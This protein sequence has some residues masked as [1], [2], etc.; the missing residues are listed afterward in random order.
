MGDYIVALS[1]W[2]PGRTRQRLLLLSAIV[3]AVAVGTGPGVAANAA[4]HGLTSIGAS[5]AATGPAGGR[6]SVA[7]AVAGPVVSSVSPTAGPLAGATTVTVLGSGFTSVKAVKFGGATATHLKVVSAAKLTVSAPSHAS[8]TVDV[9]VTTAKGTSAVSAHDQYAYVATPSVSSVSPPTGT[10]AGGTTVTVGGTGFTAVKTVTFGGIAGAGLT[11]ISA[12]ELTVTSPAHIAATVAVRVLTAGGTSPASSADQYA[13]ATPLGPVTKL[14]ASHTT[15]TVTLTWL[16]PA[17][18]SLAGVM[19]RRAQGT[20]A[21]SSPTSGTLV[22]DVT[23]AATTYT[24]TGLTPGATYSYAL[25]AYGNAGN[26]ASAATVTVTIGTLAPVD[27]S[28]TLTQDT[29]WSP[30]AASAYIIQGSLDVP[31]GVTLTIDPG[32]VVKALGSQL[33]VE[34]TLDA[35]GTAGSPVTFTSLNDNSA[36][37]T[38]GSGSPAAGDW[39]GLVINPKGSADIENAAI[40][41]AATGIEASTGGSVV[42]KDDSFASLDYEALYANLATAPTV[43]G[44]SVTGMTLDEYGSPLDCAYFVESSALDFGLLT[45]NT[46]AGKGNL[47]FGVAGEAVTSTMQA[48]SLAWAI[49]STGNDGPLDVQAG[50][51]LTI[52]PGAVVKALGSQ[53]SVEGTLDAV[54]TAGSPVTFTSLNDNSAGGTTGSGSPAA[55]DWT[56]L[57][58]NPKGSADIENAAIS[59]A[60]TGIE[61]STGG[62]VVVKDD[63][64][65]SLDYEA[66]YANLATAPTVEGNSV[67][68]MTLDEYG[69]PLDCAY[70]VES[71]ALDFGLLTGNTAAGKG[72]LCFGVAGEAVTSTMQAGS[73]AWAIASTGND[74]PLD[75]P[76]GVT[77]TIDPGAV[78]K[79]LGSQLSVEGTLDAVGTAGSPVTFTSLNDNSA[80]GTTGSGSPAAGDWTGLVINP[81][82]SADIENAAIS[83][84]ATGIEA[85]TGGSVVVKDDS[86]AS[87]DYEALYANLATAPTVEGNSVT[88][89]TLDEY[90]S[91]LDCAYFVESSALDFGLLT[92]NTAAG[93]GNLCFGVAGEAVTSTMQAG[94]LAWAI[95]STG[96]DGPLDVPGRGDADHRSGCGRQGARLAAVGGGDAGC[97][98]HGGQPGHVHLAERQQRRRDHR[99]GQSRGG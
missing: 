64:F 74:G 44:N 81:K 61:A 78:V 32:A 50:V 89:M 17:S 39:T 98:R 42:V 11:V 48:G 52:D 71:S 70:F 15:T 56:G 33:S 94:S 8:G 97:G 55:G 67:T 41:Y 40:S 1:P 90:G 80:G 31:A 22:A 57:V 68:G 63:S 29:T 23:P 4:S 46:A 20:S 87:L 34:G 37:G 83:Y 72:N 88:G 99:I 10:T 2:R 3:A 51:T 21:P 27:V 38:T 86:F 49:A 16:S 66:L 69:S 77:L 18:P 58:I 36:G 28:G 91:P 82:G 6:R 9:Q 43:E 93:K 14:K 30:A 19:I 54:G 7:A 45:G 26:Y 60:A 65:A 59:Y 47:C 62:S 53:L 84:A 73:L 85:S 35:V 25:F 12:T 5:A 79:A 13:Y 92:G 75:V 76:A 24:D 95:A 96:N